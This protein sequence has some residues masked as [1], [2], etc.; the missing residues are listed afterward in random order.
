MIEVMQHFKNGGEVEFRDKVD[1]HWIF[2]SCQP[3]WDWSRSDYRIKPKRKIKLYKWAVLISE[4]WCDDNEYYKNEEQLKKEYNSTGQTI[5]DCKRLDYTMIE[6]D[7][8]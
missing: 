3:S 4:T 7:D 1:N 6:V 2:T 8:E 5:K